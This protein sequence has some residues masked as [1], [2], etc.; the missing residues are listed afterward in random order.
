M[1][2]QPSNRP[3]DWL[4]DDNHFA[5][6][7]LFHF[8]C[9]W[10]TIITRTIFPLALPLSLFSIFDLFHGCTLHIRS[11]AHMNDVPTNKVWCSF[12]CLYHRQTVTVFPSVAAFLS[13]C[14]CVPRSSFIPTVVLHTK[15]NLLSL[16]SS[17]S[18]R[19]P[20]SP[21]PSIHFHFCTRKVSL[22]S[23]CR[24]YKKPLFN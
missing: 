19:R 23:R 1:T 22:C 16:R 10:R 21:P 6:Q 11:T 9:R 5:R 2:N 8:C 14:Y 18:F 15:L 12:R 4:S 3:T 7:I 24:S 20:P 17:S 13:M